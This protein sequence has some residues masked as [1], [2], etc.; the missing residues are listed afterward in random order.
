M[1]MCDV[2]EG[3]IWALLILGAW[4]ILGRVAWLGACEAAK[5]NLLPLHED[6]FHDVDTKAIFVVLGPL[7]LLVI[8]LMAIVTRIRMFFTPII[9]WITERFKDIVIAIDDSI[10]QYKE[11]L[12]NRWDK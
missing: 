11:E 6:S 7:M 2:M 4:A 5:Y 8:M 9:K 1:M 12:K 10:T 3:F